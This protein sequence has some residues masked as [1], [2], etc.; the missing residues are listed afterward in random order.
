MANK[1]ILSSGYSA[2]ISRKTPVFKAYSCSS[3]K[4][5]DPQSSF[6]QTLLPILFG[7]IC[8]YN[9]WGCRV[10]GLWCICN[11]LKQF[12]NWCLV[13]FH[14]HI[15]IPCISCKCICVIDT[16]P[17]GTRWWGRRLPWLHLR[18][19]VCPSVLFGDKLWQSYLSFLVLVRCHFYW[20][21][22]KT[23]EC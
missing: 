11:P 7:S 12:L 13:Q 20:I 15:E 8:L 17:L 16:L 22:N 4:W 14:W 10:L 19:G 6:H 9:H 21:E 3:L 1:S 5:H 2:V 23:K 18:L